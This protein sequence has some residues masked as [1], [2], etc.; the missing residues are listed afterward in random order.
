MFDVQHSEHSEKSTIAVP[1]TDADPV[2]L[3][4]TQ[5]QFIT[6]N[7]LHAREL[8]TVGVDLD[9]SSVSECYNLIMRFWQE[10][11]VLGIVHFVLRSPLPYLLQEFELQSTRVI[12]WS[13][14]LFLLVRVTCRNE[15]LSGHWLGISLTYSDLLWYGASDRKGYKRLSEFLSYLLCGSRCTVSPVSTRIW[16]E[17]QAVFLVVVDEDWAFYLESLEFENGWQ[18]R[19]HHSNSVCVQLMMERKIIRVWKFQSPE[20]DN[21]PFTYQQTTT[22]P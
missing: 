15:I 6:P 21:F 14:F 5:K 12:A 16:R 18:N 22:Q 7:I 4:I 1:N 19:E 17:F 20:G 3:I 8:F 11:I 13:S 2:D 9:F 10:E